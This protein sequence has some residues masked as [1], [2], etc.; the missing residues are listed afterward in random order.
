MKSSTFIAF[1]G[2]VGIVAPIFGLSAVFA[3]TLLCRVGCGEGTRWGSGGSFSWSSNALSDLGVGQVANIFNYS[4]ILVGILNFIFA[5][6]FVKAYAKSALFYLGGIL[7]ILGGGSLSLV[8]VFTEAYGVL[9]LFVSLG[10][11]VLFPIAM[12]LVGL[13]FMRMHMQTKGYP[14]MLAGI[15]ALLVILSALTLQWHIW[16]GLGF[17]VPEIVEAAVIAVWMVWMGV[18]LIRLASEKRFQEL[19]KL[20]VRKR[21]NRVRARFPSF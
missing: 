4:L 8:G 20:V 18:S 13:A 5:I 21:V 1:V 3:S 11:F 14:S 12:I 17:A 15:V 7:L 2:F 10:Y 9:H 16:L 19:K 6:G